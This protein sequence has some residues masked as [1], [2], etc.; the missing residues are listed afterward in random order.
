MADKKKKSDNNIKGARNTFNRLTRLFRYG[1]VAKSSLRSEKDSNFGKM[2]FGH[3]AGG[4]AYNTSTYFNQGYDRISRYSDY[5][6]METFPELNAALNLYADEVVT[7]DERGRVLQ[8]KTNNDKIR[9]LLETLFFDTLNIEFNAWTWIRGL[10]KWGDYF[11]LNNIDPKEGVIGVLPMPAHEVDREEGFDPTNVMASRYSWASQGKK[12]QNWQVTHFR[13]AGNEQ[14]SPYG[15]SVVEGA[16]RIWRQLILLEDAVMVYR[17]VRSPE[18]RMFK[19]D[20]GNIEP[21]EVPAYIEKMK[22]SL[23]RDQVVDQTTGRVDLRY[24]ALPLWKGTPVPLIDGSIKTLEELAYDFNDGKENWVYS[25]D[26]NTAELKHGKVVWAGKNYSDYKLLK[27]TLSDDTEILSAPEHPFILRDGTVK[28]ADALQKND[29]LKSIGIVRDENSTYI[30]YDK[31]ISVKNVEVAMFTD[32]VYCM[33]IEGPNGEQDRHNFAVFGLDNEEYLQRS[34]INCVF[35]KNSVEDDYYIPV[36]GDSSSTIETLAGGVY[37]GAIED[38]EYFQKKMF[39]ALQIPRAY[40]GYEEALSSKS[41]LAA[42]DVRWARTIQ[43]IQRVVVSEL[44][45]LAVIHLYIHGFTGEDLVDFEL[46][47]SNPSNIAEQQ[48]LELWRTRLEIAGTVPDNHFSREWMIK[49]LFQLTDKEYK[50]ILQQKKEDK[51]EDLELEAMTLP[52]SDDKNSEGDSGNEDEDFGGSIGGGMSMPSDED[53]GEEVPEESPPE[54][55]GGA[56]GGGGLFAG[57]SH[58]GDLLIEEDKEKDKVD[59]IDNILNTIRSRRKNKEDKE[60]Q[61]QDDRMK[62]KGEKNRRNRNSKIKHKSGPENLEMPDLNNA[63]DLNS[64]NKS[65]EEE[66]TID[67]LRNFSETASFMDSMYIRKSEAEMKSLI[68]E[69]EKSFPEQKKTIIVL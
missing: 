6:E 14:F 44:T 17:I 49:Q 57:K 29:D 1:P 66:E 53:V 24:K 38:L 33:T 12:L 43:R 10:C 65:R 62:D 32:D 63:A 3:M 47:L 51:I 2:A 64:K 48:K 36:R 35:V 4:T 56:E 21:S 16:R 11:L 20:V 5:S 22:T 67:P 60:E 19:I 54:E 59:N 15:T 34:K 31:A 37:A 68:K 18:R 46:R 7:Y 25:I 13:L 55:T 27:I 30:E 50:L 69:L 52:D 8:I 26:D 9:E 41:T 23:K 40:L 61:R 28:S 42:E 58:L 39:A 45:K